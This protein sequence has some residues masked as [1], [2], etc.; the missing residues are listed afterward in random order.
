MATPSGPK[1]VGH[2][3]AK[4]MWGRVE[5]GEALQ[6]L[7]VRDPWEHQQGVIAGAL[8]IPM[9]EVRARMQELDTARP[10]Y[11]IC[12]LGSRSGMVAGFLARQGIEAINVDDGMDGWERQGFPTV[13]D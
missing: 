6:I 8:L 2:T 13:R 3:D 11:V 7:D 10:V 12:H 4:H 9:S 1:P 5:A